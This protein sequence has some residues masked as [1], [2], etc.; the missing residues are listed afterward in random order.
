MKR[1]DVGGGGGARR[2][3][4]KI[5]QEPRGGDGGQDGQEK[6]DPVPANVLVV[7]PQHAALFAHADAL[8]PAGGVKRSVAPRADFGV[9]GELLA[10][11]GTDA[12]NVLGLSHAG[13]ILQ[14]KSFIEQEHRMRVAS[15]EWRVARKSSE[16]AKKRR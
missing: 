11:L 1:D 3:L 9:H 5:E 16:S 6:I 4:G 7:G 2:A 14:V 15:D 12:G 10:A 13:E 8:R